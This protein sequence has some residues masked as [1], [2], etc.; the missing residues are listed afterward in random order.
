MIS[1]ILIS[2]ILAT[3]ICSVICDTRGLYQ[4]QPQTQHHN[5]LATTGQGQD[6]FYEP[7]SSNA[8]AASPRFS[9]FE[10]LTLQTLIQPVVTAIGVIVG[11]FG[12]FQI[13]TWL[14]DLVD[15]SKKSK[16]KDVAEDKK[17]ADKEESNEIEA[18]RR[19]RMISAEVSYFKSVI[20]C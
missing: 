7:H 19:K 10:F 6:N 18:A 15:F 13:T 9:P 20:Q 11:I 2:L 4:E 1:N 3:T 17:K 12:F 16:N 5:Q 8:L 14:F